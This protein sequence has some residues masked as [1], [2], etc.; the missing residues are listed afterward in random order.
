[1]STLRLGID[2]GSTT[3]KLVMIDEKDALIHAIYRRTTRKHTPPCWAC[4]PKRG[5]I[6]VMSTSP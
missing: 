5:T 3:A 2:L 1:M 6:S 4:F